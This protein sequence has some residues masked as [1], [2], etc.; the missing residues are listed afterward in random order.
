V[1]I[2]KGNEIIVDKEDTLKRKEE[3]K[4]LTKIYGYN[5]RS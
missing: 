4:E 1:L 2:I 5:K 3:V